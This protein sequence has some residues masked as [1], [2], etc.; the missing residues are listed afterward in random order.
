MGEYYTKHKDP[1]QLMERFKGKDLERELC[2]AAEHTFTG[3]LPR[4]YAEYYSWL[5]LAAYRRIK[6]LEW[7]HED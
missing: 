2:F 4:K 5:A 6:E 1:E 3:Y 7:Q